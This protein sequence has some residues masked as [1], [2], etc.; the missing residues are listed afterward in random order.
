[1]R[2]A[3]FYC[4]VARATVSLLPDF[5]AARYRATLADIERVI[6][7]VE[8]SSS[9]AA[10]ADEL[11]PDDDPR[12]VTSI[13]AMRWVRRRVKAVYAT[14]LALVTLLPEVLGCAPTLG[15]L[16]AHLGEGRVLVRL[17]AIAASSMHALAPPLGVCPR[18]RR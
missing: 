13:S 2:V 18:G 3:R 5:V 7:V 15:A 11:R 8:R 16:A 9:M 10:A 14:L 6:E 17:R 1:M 4:P 12:A